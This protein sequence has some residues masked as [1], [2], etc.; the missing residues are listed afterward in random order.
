MST[1]LYKTLVFIA[2]VIVGLVLLPHL[3]WNFMR[4]MLDGFAAPRSRWPEVVLLS[5][6]VYLGGIV[7]FW[8]CV[9]WLTGCAT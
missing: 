9:Y 2:V 6:V 1:V 5:A 7:L 3:L 8:S 4:Y